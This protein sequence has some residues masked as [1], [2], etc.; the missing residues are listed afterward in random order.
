MILAQAASEYGGAT[1]LG[2]LL[3]SIDKTTGQLQASIQEHP[4]LWI[5]GGIILG[6]WLFSRRS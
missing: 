2:A 3:S 5:V 6:L 4:V 1:G